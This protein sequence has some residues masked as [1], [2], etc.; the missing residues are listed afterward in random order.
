MGDFMNNVNTKVFERELL[1]DN[2]VVLK[3]HI[4]YPCISDSSGNWS[5]MKFNDY[6][7]ALALEVKNRAETELYQ[8][9]IQ[10]YLYNKENGY[11]VMVFEVYRNFEV[12]YDNFPFL[13]L[14]F[15]EYIFSG[16]AH[17]NTI[18]SSQNWNLS[19]GRMIPLF[20]F[21]PRNPYF[22]L[23]ILKQ[24]NEQ[25]AKEPNVYFENACG[26]VLDAFNPESFYLTPQGIAI[27][28][29][30]YDIAPYSSGIRVFTVVWDEYILSIYQ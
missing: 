6:N 28:F 22:L 10:T 27:Y 29:Q 2:V 4:E 12:T 5:I 18:R 20:R 14:Y 19:S 13:S 9:A 15:D 26:L 11:P 3:Y 23:D 24:I 25:I 17:G 7:C 30:Q 1:Y 16:G 8:E 21:F